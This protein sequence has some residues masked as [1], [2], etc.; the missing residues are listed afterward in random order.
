M[1]GNQ[2][3]IFETIQRYVDKIFSQINEA[4]CR[5]SFVLATHPNSSHTSHASL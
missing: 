4:D 1:L 2:E 3:K 5:F